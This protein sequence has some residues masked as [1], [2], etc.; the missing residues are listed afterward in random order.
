M[1]LQPSPSLRAAEE[2]R[3][4]VFT[5]PDFEAAGFSQRALGRLRMLEGKGVQL[6]EAVLEKLGIPAPGSGHPKADGGRQ[7]GQVG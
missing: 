3:K 4:E 1:L 5:L 7:A 2:A 6:T